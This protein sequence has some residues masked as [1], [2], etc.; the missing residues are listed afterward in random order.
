M[1]DAIT[2]AYRAERRLSE[3]MERFKSLEQNKTV[4][5]YIQLARKLRKYGYF[6]DALLPKDKRELISLLENNVVYHG[7][8]ENK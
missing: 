7:P 1:T 4:K 3:D 8:D 6:W 2:E 5:E